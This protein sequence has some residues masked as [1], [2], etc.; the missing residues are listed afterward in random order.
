M[1]PSQHTDEVG[2]VPALCERMTADLRRI[3]SRPR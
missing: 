3:S 1:K 2:E